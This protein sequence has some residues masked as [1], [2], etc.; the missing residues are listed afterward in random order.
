MPVADELPGDVTEATPAG[1]F[2]D[3]IGDTIRV[4]TVTDVDGWKVH[5][6]LYAGV[7]DRVQIS[8]GSPDG[9]DERSAFIDRASWA[10]LTAPLEGDA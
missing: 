2:D 4:R 9:T 1:A 5:R 10:Y 6:T 7:D 8:I 3:T